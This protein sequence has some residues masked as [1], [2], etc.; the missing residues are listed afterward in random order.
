MKNKERKTFI[1]DQPGVCMTEEEWAELQGMT[2][3]ELRTPTKLDDFYD[4]AD[5]KIKDNNENI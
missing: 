1:K 4:K 5:K 3:S 2:A